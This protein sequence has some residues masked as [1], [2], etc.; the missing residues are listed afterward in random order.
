MRFVELVRGRESRVD[1]PAAQ[2]VAGEARYWIEPDLPAGV[3]LEVSDAGVPSIGGEAED[4]QPFMAYRL[5]VQDDATIVF[6]AI[7]IGVAKPLILSQPVPPAIL[8]AGERFQLTRP[9]GGLLPA[10]RWIEDIEGSLEFD[11]VAYG[12][13]AAQ[14]DYAFEYY[15]R[16]GIQQI[17]HEV[18]GAANW[19]LRFAWKASPGDVLGFT[20]DDFLGERSVTSIQSE[21][22]V[23][24][25][26]NALD[27]D[28]AFLTPVA[29]GPIAFLARKTGP[30]SFSSNAISEF[31]DPADLTV[32]G[33]PCQYVEW[34]HPSSVPFPLPGATVEIRF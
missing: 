32:D 4:A 9:R 24:Q 8:A 31:S 19:R 6:R 27:V 26:P 21:V 34:H 29:A 11:A 33:I 16:S 25:W 2:N 28:V 17:H 7:R 30:A 18:T 22:V 23:P 13:K 15:V 20:E 14:G 1:L 12:I 10:Q 5:F 3:T